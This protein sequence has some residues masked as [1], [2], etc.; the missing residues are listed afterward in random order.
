MAKANPTDSQPSK[1]PPSETVPHYRTPELP[2]FS[3][4]SC[5]GPTTPAFGTR[6]PVPKSRPSLLYSALS[7][8]RPALLCA[9]PALCTPLLAPLSFPFP[10]LAVRASPSALCIYFPPAISVGHTLPIGHPRRPFPATHIPATHIPP[11]ASRPS[12]PIAC[13]TGDVLRTAPVPLPSFAVRS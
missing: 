6:P 4:K 2:A 12:T 11:T 5:R 10:S 1:R 8:L 7:V 13:A 3:A 9:L